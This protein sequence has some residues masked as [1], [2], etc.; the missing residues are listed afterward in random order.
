MPTITYALPVLPGK[1][2][3]VR[4][5][6]SEL[7]PHRAAYDELNRRATVTRHDIYLQESPQGALVITI[8][9]TDDP[10]RLLRPFADNPHDNWWR[11]WNKDVH[12]IDPADVAPADFRAGELVFTSRE[13]GAG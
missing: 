4:N 6:R 8:M 1:D 12:G 3:R 13:A 2:E 9:E 5:F 10:S 7:E 11:A